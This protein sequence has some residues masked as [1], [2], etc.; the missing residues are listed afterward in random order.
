MRGLIS[1]V[2]RTIAADL[3]DRQGSGRLYAP[4]RWWTMIRLR[5]A[6]PA[7]FAVTLVAVVAGMTPTA[8]AAKPELNLTEHPDVLR[9][10]DAARVVAE[11]EGVAVCRL[12]LTVAGGAPAGSSPVRTS[13]A[14]AITWTWRGGPATGAGRRGGGG[15]GGGE[16]A[17]G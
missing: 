1:I 16:R 10:G 14:K 4:P 6:Y 11:V 7:A 5:Q 2:V 9:P 8:A 12:D 17:R 15:G 3:P 13:D